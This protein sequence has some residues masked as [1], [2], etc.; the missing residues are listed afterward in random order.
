MHDERIAE[1]R[2]AEHRA[3]LLYVMQP[4]VLLSGFRLPAFE[5]RSSGGRF[6]GPVCLQELQSRFPNRQLIRCSTEERHFE[7]LSGSAG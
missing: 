1:C 3:P 2:D 6:Q 4:P 5:I 7:E